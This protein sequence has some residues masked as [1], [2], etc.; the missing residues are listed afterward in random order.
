MDLKE[1]LRE[2]G[3]QASAQ[4]LAV[5]EYVLRTGQHPTAD[6][7]YS[8]V[9]SVLPMVSRATIYNTLNLFVQKGLLRRQLIKEG[10]TI[11]DA[12]MEPHH[13]F[14][15]DMTGQ[16][17]DLPWDSIHVEPGPGLDEFEITDWH[18]VIK[19][20]VPRSTSVDKD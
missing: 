15:D 19:G 1:R 12:R 2:A 6:Q 9:R 5:G 20:R 8:G 7:V 10:C 11:Y 3:I 17:H 13:H 4:R 16:I 14:I 18:V